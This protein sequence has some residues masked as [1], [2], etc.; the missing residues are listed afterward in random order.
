MAVLGEQEILDVA[1]LSNDSLSYNAGHRHLE[2]IRE[3]AA[4]KLRAV[5]QHLHDGTIATSNYSDRTKKRL[6]D[7]R[8]AAPNERLLTML[9]KMAAMNDFEEEPKKQHGDLIVPGFGSIGGDRYYSAEKTAEVAAD[10]VAEH[11]Q[12]NPDFDQHANWVAKNYLAPMITRD[13][14]NAAGVYLTKS[15]QTQPEEGHSVRLGQH[16]FVIEDHGM[17]GRMR[18]TTT[19]GGSK[20]FI[21]ETIQRKHDELGEI[22]APDTK[23]VAQFEKILDQLAENNE[24]ASPADLLRKQK[25]IV[26]AA[27]IVVNAHVAAHQAPGESAKKEV[28]R[29]ARTELNKLMPRAIP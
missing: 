1:G 28:F 9:G 3:N 14:A 15:P 10:I 23:T 24:D 19:D 25:Q 22:A 7:V 8:T 18:R 12:E 5:L 21:A 27:E 16:H 29:K 17:F 26:A 20:Y 13:V 2:T 6:S 4:G 11:L